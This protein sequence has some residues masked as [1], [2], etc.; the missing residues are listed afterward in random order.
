MNIF[1]FKIIILKELWNVHFRAK[2]NVAKASKVSTEAT[3]KP[4]GKAKPKGNAKPPQ[5]P[6]KTRQQVQKEAI[7]KEKNRLSQQVSIL[8]YKHIAT[9][10]NTAEYAQ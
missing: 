4:K 2:Q 5:T 6:T 9:S 3:V 10:I 1:H 8:N 7:R